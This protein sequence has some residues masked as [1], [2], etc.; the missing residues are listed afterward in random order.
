MITSHSIAAAIS[1][2]KKYEN[3]HTPPQAARLPAVP[4]LTVDNRTL[5]TLRGFGRRA[6][7]GS[8]IIEIPAAKEDLRLRHAALAFDVAKVASIAACAAY[9]DRS[10]DLADNR[11]AAATEAAADRALAHFYDGYPIQNRFRADKAATLT[12]QEKTQCGTRSRSSTA[13]STGTG[14]R[15]RGR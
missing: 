15:P 6:V 11:I 3:L 2:L 14:T 7:Q 5:S 13:H 4:I 9:H 12:P 1:N 8:D 10:D